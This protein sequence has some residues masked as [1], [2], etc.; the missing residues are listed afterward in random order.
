MER[1]QARILLRKINQIF[2]AITD[3]GS[4]PSRIEADLLLDYTRQF[5]NALI[6]EPEMKETTTAMQEV[7]SPARVIVPESVPAPPD[8][9]PI[10]A[11]QET[12]VSPGSSKEET[13][14]TPSESEHVET[15]P[16]TVHPVSVP[17]PVSLA[18]ELKTNGTQLAETPR[19]T[20]RSVVADELFT[21][22][23]ARDLS[24]KLRTSPIDDL[25][26]AMGINER[27]LT[28]N[29]LFHG[30]HAAFDQA[31]R[32]LNDL[33]TFSS[34]RTF[35]EEEIIPRYDW[36]DAKRQKKAMVFIQLVRRRFL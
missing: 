6:A 31:L 33:S 26:R 36:M 25:S 18:P 8:P 32:R 15:V 30:D 19:P 24:D 17:E 12:T 2:D 22:E 4:D 10:E 28:I 27:F 7:I 1:T 11:M 5:Y 16:P 34:A 23:E 21:T 29:E 14:D 20:G 13:R 3:S 35:L 9:L